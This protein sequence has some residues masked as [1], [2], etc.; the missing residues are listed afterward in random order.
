[1]KLSKKDQIGLVLY[2]LM[3]IPLPPVWFGTAV[4]GGAQAKP[5]SLR[6][7]LLAGEIIDEPEA[8]QEHMSLT[9]GG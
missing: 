2:S 6:N 3:G 9:V 5:F 8:K 7:D 4:S 1:V